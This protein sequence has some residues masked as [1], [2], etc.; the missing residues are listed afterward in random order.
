MN[1]CRLPKLCRVSSVISYVILRTSA[2]PVFI[3][4]KSNRK[5]TKAEQFP[6]KHA[7]KD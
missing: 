5:L 7:A 6:P 2:V 3:Y 1:A 4:H